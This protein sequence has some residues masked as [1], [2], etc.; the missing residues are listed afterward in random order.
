MAENP[1]GCANWDICWDDRGHFAEP[2][3]GKVIGLGT[4]AVRKYLANVPENCFGAVLFVEKE[5]FM[6][7]FEKVQLAARYDI[8]I[9]SAKGL[10]TT[11]CRTLVDVLCGE[12]AVPLAALHDFDK[13]GFS[14]LGTLSRDTRR[15][16]FKN[17]FKIIDLGLRLDDVLAHHLEPEQVVYPRPRN[18]GSASNP[19]LNLRENGATE[20]EIEFLV[21]GGNEWS[22]YRGQRVELNTFSSDNLI[23]FVEGK[24]QGHG[25]KKVVPDAATLKMAYRDSTRDILLS[26]RLREIQAK[27]A[28]EVDKEIATMAVPSNL[29]RQVRQLLTREPQIP[30]NA[31][32]RRL[33]ATEHDD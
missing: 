33:A 7:L 13:S 23:G 16:A 29:S 11:A 24:L 31:A 30:W 26:E 20:A 15:Y 3:T 9:I 32:I 21:T 22:G 17:S 8:A 6:P 12:K 14:I 1:E 25:I 18:S 28:A 4:L 10:S 2:H 5:G 27:I 19:S